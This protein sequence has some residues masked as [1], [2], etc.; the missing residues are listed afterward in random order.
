MTI[1]EMESKW[2]VS[3]YSNYYIYNIYVRA[4]EKKKTKERREGKLRE[5]ERERTREMDTK[6]KRFWIKTRQSEGPRKGCYVRFL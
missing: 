4:T 2:M 3:I 5:R 1:T 6:T